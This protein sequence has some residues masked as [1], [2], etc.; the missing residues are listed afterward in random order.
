MDDKCMELGMQKFVWLVL[1]SGQGRTVIG[2]EQL[3][4]MK[5]LHHLC[6]LRNLSYTFLLFQL[7]YQ[8]HGGEEIV[9][10][11]VPSPSHTPGVGK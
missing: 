4:R 8:F 6:R 5:F 3:S 10:G 7:L 9:C 2:F 1:V 11:H